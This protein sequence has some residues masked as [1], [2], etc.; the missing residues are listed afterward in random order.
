MTAGAGGSRK[1]KGRRRRKGEEKSV[2]SGV[3]TIGGEEASASGLVGEE[4]DEDEV[5]VDEGVQ[6][7]EGRK[8][9][10]AA[11]KKNLA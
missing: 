10:K 4:E 3:K 11:E 5:D 8:V 2:R 7:E 1:G 9:D 6:D